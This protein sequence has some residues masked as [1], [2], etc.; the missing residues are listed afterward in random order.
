MKNN[1]G[2]AARAIY[3]RTKE[4]FSPQPG[5]NFTDY[6]MSANQKATITHGNFNKN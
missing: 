5:A 4:G 3:L 1:V 2:N 6:V